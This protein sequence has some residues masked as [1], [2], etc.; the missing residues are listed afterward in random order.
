MVLAP[1]ILA[2]TSDPQYSAGMLGAQQP[3]T[4]HLPSTTAPQGFGSQNHAGVGYG[5][6]SYTFPVNQQLSS[7]ANGDA[8]KVPINSAADPTG[9][10]A[11]AAAS[12]LGLNAVDGSS[13]AVPWNNEAFPVSCSTTDV[14]AAA[15]AQMYL[16]QN[17]F[18]GTGNA[19]PVN[20]Y[21]P[22][23]QA[24]A[25]TPYMMDPMAQWTQQ[26]TQMMAYY[27]NMFPGMFGY[28]SSNAAGYA[29]PQQVQARQQVQPTRPSATG[30]TV[31]VMRSSEST[32]SVTGVAHARTVRSGGPSAASSIFSL[33]AH[34][35]PVPPKDSAEAAAPLPPPPP[36]D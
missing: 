33:N 27:P 7:T 14:D 24:A 1:P 10:D 29:A 23:F 13:S 19:L 20:G 11:P 26:M 31:S 12:S 34:N 8:S 6:E 32:S 5:T 22:A 28:A 15:A 16:P 30:G 4:T 9:H 35:V 18:S 36:E 17:G 2:T 3:H 21:Y 25:P